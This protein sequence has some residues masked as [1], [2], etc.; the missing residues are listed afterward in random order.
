ME[1]IYY[2]KSSGLVCHRFPNDLEPESE[3]DF[4][5]V[6]KEEASKTYQ[7]PFGKVWKV[8]DGKLALEGKECSAEEHEAIE[9]ANRLN[10]IAELKKYLEDTDYIVIKMA[11]CYGDDKALKAI[12]DEYPEQLA[13]RKEARARINELEGKIE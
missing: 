2:V 6:S 1:K 4:I 13:K 10:E 8:K 7:C 9:K 11:E 5:E 12:R 3:N